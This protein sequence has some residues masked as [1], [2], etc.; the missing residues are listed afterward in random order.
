[1]FVT[2]TQLSNTELF[3]FYGQTEMV[4]EFIADLLMDETECLM[5]FRWVE[6]P[7]K[8]KDFGDSTTDYYEL[9]FCDS[10]VSFLEAQIFQGAVYEAAEITFPM[11]PETLARPVLKV[12]K[13]HG[14]LALCKYYP[15]ERCKPLSTE[16]AIKELKKYEYHLKTARQML[17]A[18][19]M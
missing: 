4:T 7:E 8:H 13:V 15:C 1:M 19:Y 11:D 14:R 3:K 17:L 5:G 18:Y 12:E 10:E 2:D 6:I 9:K 16:E